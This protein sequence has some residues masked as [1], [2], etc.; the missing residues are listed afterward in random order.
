LGCCEVSKGVNNALLE[1]VCPLSSAV[2]YTKN[3]MFVTNKNL[4][5]LGP[6]FGENYL[7]K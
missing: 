5:E 1:S 4:K 6:E 2:E 7:E 3:L